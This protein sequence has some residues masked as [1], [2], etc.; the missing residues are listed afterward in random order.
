M[1][2]GKI[3][4]IYEKYGY[5][6]DPHSAVGY[7]AVKHLDVDGFY[8]STAHAAKFGEVVEPAAGVAPALPP[9]LAEACGRERKST[10]IEA[11]D[12]ALRE[13]LLKM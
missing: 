12:G 6:S 7:L 11:T 9:S 2:G 3:S 8:L 1:L 4:E 5:L 10:P 13:F